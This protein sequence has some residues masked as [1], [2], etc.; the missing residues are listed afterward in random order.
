M[1]ETNLIVRAGM[2]VIV[3]VEACQGHGRCRLISPALFDIENEKV[4][5]L[6]ESVPVGGEKSAKHG[7]LSCPERAISIVE[8]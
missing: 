3:D 2:R 7:M 8:G 1:V 5:L 4:V 6:S